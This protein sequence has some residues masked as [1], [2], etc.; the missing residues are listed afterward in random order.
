MI[1]KSKKDKDID[2]ENEKIELAKNFLNIEERIIKFSK[3]NSK[4][5]DILKSIGIKEGTIEKNN[6][7]KETL[8]YQ[9]QLNDVVI[10]EIEKEKIK[11]AQE[12]ANSKERQLAFQELEAFWKIVEKTS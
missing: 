10:E 11:L 3:K 4:I 6:V 1:F 2:N 7:K 9:Y 12:V 8:D 5:R